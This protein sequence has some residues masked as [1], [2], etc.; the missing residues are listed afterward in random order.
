MT[1]KQK[2]LHSE[3]INDR[4]V[5][6]KPISQFFSNFEYGTADRLWEDVDTQG[7]EK[8]HLRHESGVQLKIGQN[9]GDKYYRQ[10]RRFIRYVPGYPLQYAFAFQFPP[11]TDGLRCRIGPFDDKNGVF[12]EQEDQKYKIVRRTGVT[13]T[14]QDKEVPEEEWDI[15]TIDFSNVNMI[16]FTVLWYGGGGIEVRIQ[17]GPNTRLVY[18]FEGSDQRNYPIMGPPSNPIRVE[19]E[20]TSSQNK[21]HAIKM[22]GQKAEL[23]G[24]DTFATDPYS[25]DLGDNF[26]AVSSPE[27]ILAIRPKTNFNGITNRTRILPRSIRT[28]ASGNANFRVLRNVDLTLTGSGDWSDVNKDSSVE[29]VTASEIDSIDKSDAR[30]QSPVPTAG[31]QGKSSGD[32]EIQLSRRI[33]ISL[34]YAGNH[35]K[36]STFVVEAQNIAGSGQSLSNVDVYTA[37]LWDEIK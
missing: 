25:V 23:I 19:I 20:N 10:T 5:S 13:G 14:A 26:V 15:R 8:N 1:N 28:L 17:L 29:F 6:V 7:A 34:D 3:S 2:K 12:I 37:L 27:P 24:T 31:G 33:P 35:D 16:S 22:Y 9:K 18:F 30:E 11:K 4:M 36:E 32:A 21:D